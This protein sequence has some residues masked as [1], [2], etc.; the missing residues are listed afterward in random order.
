MEPIPDEIRKYPIEH[1]ES[2][3]EAGILGK[4]STGLGEQYFVVPVHEHGPYVVTNVTDVTWR[5]GHA[6]VTYKCEGCLVGWSYVFG[7]G[8]EW[9]P[10]VSALC[11]VRN[12]DR[13]SA[14]RRHAVRRHGAPVNVLEDPNT[15][16]VDVWHKVQHDMRVLGHPVTDLS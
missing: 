9:P 12:G 8:S 6:R 4:T 13:N 16:V 5:D 11:E 2:L 15:S 10:L 1:L 7:A 3:V 14:L